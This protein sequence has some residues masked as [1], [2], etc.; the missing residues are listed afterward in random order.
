MSSRH[1]RALIA[2]LAASLAAGCTPPANE[3]PP[4]VSGAKA[5]ATADTSPATT[6]APKALGPSDTIRTNGGELRI[7]PIH[8]GT[9]MLEYDGKVIHIDPWSEGN[10]LAGVP[11]ADL[12]LITDIHGD[13]FDPPGLAQVVK[14]STIVMAP[15]V[16]VEKHPSAVPIKNG[17]IRIFGTVHVEAVPMY[18][19]KRGP[20]EGK[21]F[22]DKGRGNGYVLKFAEKKV[23]VS[24]DTE[25]T[26][27]MRALKE[28]DVAFVCM[29]LPYTMPPSEAAECIKAFRPKIVFPYH[30]RGSDLGE[31]ERAL[32]PEKDIELRVRTWY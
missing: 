11:K 24:G 7:T 15:P 19:E 25:C 23:Y 12:V 14:P 26:A 16:V 2:L 10:K 17:E 8:H 6:A 9:L 4:S 31:L 32:T 30:H 22:H 3:A 5:G 27:E 28:V 21:L 18:N 29:N 13:H 20:S 1:G